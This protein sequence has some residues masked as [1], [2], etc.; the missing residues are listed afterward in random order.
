[1]FPKI[2]IA[3]DGIMPIAKGDVEGLDKFIFDSNEAYISATINTERN[4]FFDDV[5][6]G[7]F[8]GKEQ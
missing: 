5:T 3:T 7:I 2:C 1:M 6:I 8:G 4:S